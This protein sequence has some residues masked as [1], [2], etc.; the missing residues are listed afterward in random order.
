MG[1]A[2][3]C[4]KANVKKGPWSPEEDAKLKAYIDQHGTG[5]NWIAL[6][7]KVGLKRCGK[8]CRLR[9]LNYLRPNIKHGGFSEEED[10]IICSLYISIGSRW[11]IIAAQLPGRTDN[12]I[13]NY[14]NTRLKKKLLGRR[15]QSNMNNMSSMGGETKD[16]NGQ[17]DDS[18]SPGLSSSAF[19]RLQ[20]HMQLQSLQNPLSFYN[21]PA[22]WPKLHP[23]QEKMIQNLQSLNEFPNTPL[24]EHALPSPQPVQGQKVGF[25]ESPTAAKVNELKSLHGISSSDNSVAFINENNSMDST[26]VPKAK[27]IEQSNAGIQASVFQAEIDNF[28]NTKTVDFVPQEDQ[29]A[30]FDCFKEMNVS[31][32]G[33]LWW[34]TND[35][36]ARSASLNAWES[37]SVLRPQQIFQE[38]E[39]GYNL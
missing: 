16:A 30:E 25:Y 34:S 28:L 18:Y 19:E 26:H 4:D 21:N 27:G 15:K 9:W 37:T 2:P 35:F 8:S 11:S 12:D 1:R 29:M 17:E 20:L 24:M 14:W 22:L 32:D 13:K 5:G 7:Q 23:L 38:Y 6:P 3:C 36:D 39:L 10:N 31:K 33:V